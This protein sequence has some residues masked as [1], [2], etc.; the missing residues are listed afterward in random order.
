MDLGAVAVPAG[1]TPERL[2]FGVSLIA[3]AW[4]DADLLGWL[5]D[6]SAPPC[7]RSARRPLPLP[8]AESIPVDTSLVDVMVCGRPHVRPAVEQ[9]IART[10]RAADKHHAHCAIYRFY[11][12]PGGPPYRP[13]L[14]QVKE[15]GI[16]VEWKS[17][18][19]RW[20]TLDR[21]LAGFPRRSASAR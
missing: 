10:R 3:P 8:A 12:L 1:F 5:A 21:S 16:A 11:A 7:R 9:A 13:G 19:C 2:P 17:G 4:S 15:G 14:V 6:C 18:A 20:S